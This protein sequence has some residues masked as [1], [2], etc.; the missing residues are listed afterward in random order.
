LPG[1][2][3]EVGQLETR[4][5]PHPDAVLIHACDVVRDASN[6]RQIYELQHMPTKPDTSEDK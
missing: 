4:T 1:L 6:R 5:G 2:D 3:R